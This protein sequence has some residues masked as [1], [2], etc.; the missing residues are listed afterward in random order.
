[1][2]RRYNAPTPD[3]HRY[4]THHRYDGLLPIREAAPADLLTALSKL[5]VTSAQ[6]AVLRE[7]S[8]CPRCG[9][10]GPTVRDFGV[11]VLGGK[12]KS[13]SWCRLCR[14]QSSVQAVIRRG[15]PRFVKADHGPLKQRKAKKPRTPRS[16]R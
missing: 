7:V 1:M 2:T 4:A 15:Q 8:V 11:R 3:Q 10:E 6:L 13:Q 5:G 12:V 9:H 14:A 16:D